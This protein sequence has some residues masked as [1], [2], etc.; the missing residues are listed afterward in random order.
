MKKVTALWMPSII[1]PE[2]VTQIIIFNCLS[3]IYI[4]LIMS[5][6]C[7]FNGTTTLTHKSIKCI[8]LNFTH[9]NAFF[10]GAD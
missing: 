1:L 10:F 7:I 8:N 5:S 3:L 4:I 9:Q 6:K 2:C